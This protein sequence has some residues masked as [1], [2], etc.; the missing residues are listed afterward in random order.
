MRID[1]LVYQMLLWYVR[2]VDDLTHGVHGCLSLD[3]ST[4]QSNC[5]KNYFYPSRHKDILGHLHYHLH[6]QYLSTLIASTTV[7]RFVSLTGLVWW[8]PRS[9]R[10]ESMGFSFENN[11]SITIPSPDLAGTTGASGRK[12]N[13]CFPPGLGKLLHMF[14]HG[15]IILAHYGWF[16]DVLVII[17]HVRYGSLCL[18]V[19]A[20]V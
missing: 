9:G 1:S 15:T 12:K 18:R 2:S 11:V 19:S 6:Y 7:P 16:D 5:D 17:L 13:T 14:R 3:L 20:R 8:T 10:P 4:P